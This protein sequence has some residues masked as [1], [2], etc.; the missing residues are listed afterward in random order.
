MNRVLGDE[1]L[2][3]PCR[4]RDE[5]RGTIVQ[6]VHR[7]DLEWVGKVP[8]PCD[9]RVPHLC[10]V[11]TR[12]LVSNQPTRTATRY[13]KDSGTASASRLKGSP[14]GVMTAAVTKIPMIA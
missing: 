5:N 10:H 6:G 9:E 14:E 11:V 3:G 4:G 2:A 7:L 12:F 8:E 1:G 13:S